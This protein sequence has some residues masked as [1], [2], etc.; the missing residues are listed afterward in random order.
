MLRRIACA[1]KL[2]RFIKYHHLSQLELLRNHINFLLTS[3]ALDF[4][5][6]DL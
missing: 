4:V 3:C 1:H 6:R 2:V 5:S